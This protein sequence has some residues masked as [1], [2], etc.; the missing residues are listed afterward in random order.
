MSTV[1]T[2]VPASAHRHHWQS[3]A[4][5]QARMPDGA[6]RLCTTCRCRQR[7]VSG[8]W[9]A[10]EVS[11]RLLVETLELERAHWATRSERLHAVAGR[12]GGLG[13][14]RAEEIDYADGVVYGLDLALQVVREGGGRLSRRV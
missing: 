2:G 13:D 11:A 7:K 14:D 5:Q 8:R 10:E 6:L 1:R 3:S 12:P 4:A 9:V